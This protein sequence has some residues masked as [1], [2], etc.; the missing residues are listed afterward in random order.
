MKPWSSSHQ[1]GPAQRTQA[2]A[3]ICLSSKVIEIPCYKLTNTIWHS[4]SW[5]ITI[6]Q[7]YLGTP[8]SVKVLRTET[9][10]RLSPSN[11]HLNVWATHHTIRPQYLISPEGGMPVPSSLFNLQSG[12]TLRW[13][14]IYFLHSMKNKMRNMF[15]QPS[16]PCELRGII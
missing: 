15:L 7:W 10:K 12:S 14:K 9:P 13:L 6:I 4:L 8:D 5:N 11:K 3:S 1:R 16:L 2:N